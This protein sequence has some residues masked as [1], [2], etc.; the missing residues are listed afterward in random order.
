MTENTHEPP[1]FEDPEDEGSS[2]LL[3]PPPTL[4]ERIAAA[5]RARTLQIQPSIEAP[6]STPEAEKATDSVTP[7]TGS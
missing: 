7:P 1:E 2:T 3:V 5:Q 6:E 4:R